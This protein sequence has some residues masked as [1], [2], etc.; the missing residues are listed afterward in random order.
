MKNYNYFPIKLI[1]NKIVLVDGIART[2]KLL[3]GSFISSFNNTEHFELG[4]NFEHIL[5]AVKFN[6]VEINF[7]KSFIHN[8][9]NQLVYNKYISRNV[10]FRPGDR[11]GVHQSQNPKLYFKR[12][13]IKDGDKIIKKVK[14]DKSIFPIVT[15]E[16]AVNFDILKKLKL[17]FKIIEILRSPID[18]VYSW[19]M[20]G[21]GKRFGKDQ[22][23]F[24]LLI[25]KKDK[26]YPWY[27][28]LNKKKIN[29]ENEVEKCINLVS[30]LIKN[31]ISNLKRFK[32]KIFITS[33][34]NLTQ[35]TYS[36][37]R[38]IA[39]FLGTKTNSKTHKFIKRENCPIKFDKTKFEKKKL[40]IK[41][42]CSDNLFKKIIKLQKQYEQNLYGLRKS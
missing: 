25:N 40:F 10:N 20:R 38:K 3:L 26:I 28:I 23:A 16:L 35:N 7:A 9:L 30:L 32:K 31:S 5:P 17:E 39:Y 33:Y 21:W 14:Q 11:T 36:E 4:E 1:S 2:G 22:R 24:T 29:K 8:Y 37:I 42:N 12:L 6:K 19:Y 15:H 34:E 41:K 18:T 27:S 13:K